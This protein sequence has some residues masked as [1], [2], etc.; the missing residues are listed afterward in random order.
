MELP[1]DWSLTMASDP[2]NE[3]PHDQAPGTVTT[4]T[5]PSEAIQ[6][7][8]QATTTSAQVAKGNATAA[9]DNADPLDLGR[10]RRSNITQAQMKADYPQ[11]NKKRMK[12]CDVNHA[13]QA[14]LTGIEILHQTEPVDRPVPA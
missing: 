7:P 12:V 5:A 3:Q 8:S 13:S 1:K 10:H 2:T 6:P 4:S 14:M 9:I 11:A